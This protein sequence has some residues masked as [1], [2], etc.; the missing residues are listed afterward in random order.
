ME[1]L[2]NITKLINTLDDEN[3]D[4]INQ[5]SQA[6]E[7][8]STD[9]GWAILHENQDVL[10]SKLNLARRIQ[11]KMKRNVN[12]KRE[13][14]VYLM[15]V[16]SGIFKEINLLLA[17][18]ERKNTFLEIMTCL[19]QK[20]HIPEILK[21]LYDNPDARHKDIASAIN[22]NTNQASE[23][24]NELVQARCIINTKIGKTSIYA[25]T[26]DG[27]R[28][29][30]KQIERS[31]AESL[32]NDIDDKVQEYFS[33]NSNCNARKNEINWSTIEDKMRVQ[34]DEVLRSVWEEKIKENEIRYFLDF[35][36]LNKTKYRSSKEKSRINNDMESFMEHFERCAT[37]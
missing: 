24:L 10:I 6:V 32:Y 36:C 21:F 3:E 13:E 8:F 28:F 4:I 19:Y 14:F 23:L 30:K 35:N 20:K 18:L 7:E 37:K 5:L 25:L 2:K 33:G 26:M 34:K 12:G 29:L 27:V 11:N 1:Y 16:F 15:G 9:C 31:Q 22:V 17:P